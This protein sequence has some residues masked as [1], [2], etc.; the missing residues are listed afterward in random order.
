MKN[1]I[2]K[3][4]RKVPKPN[5]SS[6]Q[7]VYPKLEEF[8]SFENVK[9]STIT[10]WIAYQMAKNL[11]VNEEQIDLFF[12]KP[13]IQKDY[14]E[15]I[16]PEAETILQLAQSAT[17]W[18]QNDS[19]IEE[20]IKQLNLSPAYTKVLSRVIREV[21]TE[22]DLQEKAY[23]E[24][25]EIWNVYRD[26]IYSASQGHFLLVEKTDLIRYKS[27]KLLCEA[28]IKQREDIPL[29]RNAATEVFERVN[30][31]PSKMMSYKLIVSEAVT[32]VLKHAEYGKLLIYQDEITSTLRVIIEDTGKGFPLKILP[33][34]TLMAGYSTKKSMG[35]GFNL[36][37]KMADQLVL[38][39]STSG[40][41]LILILKGENEN[42]E[43][44]LEPRN[45]HTKN[46]YDSQVI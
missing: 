45:D 24:S 8:S 26:V 18:I 25:K 5:D 22:K 38:E 4:L 28:E 40:S 13:F 33:Q 14:Q 39:T 6:L 43:N 1:S 19:L 27:G 7:T 17:L 12:L 11:S 2:S 34:T 15:H 32:N 44:K 35:Q 16:E 46:N 23:S 31:K 36:M 3:F 21:Q 20:E 29:A 10:G 41:T 9:K 37:L 42:V 30:L